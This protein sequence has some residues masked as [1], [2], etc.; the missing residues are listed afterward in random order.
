LL[1]ALERKK[2]QG[3]R[4]GELVG[5]RSISSPKTLAE[6]AMVQDKLVKEEFWPHTTNPLSQQCQNMKIKLGRQSDQLRQIIGALYF[7]IFEEENQNSHDF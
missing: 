7:F 4:S 2:S 5:P 3:A 6:S 1:T